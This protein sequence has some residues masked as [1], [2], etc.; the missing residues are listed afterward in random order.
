MALFSKSSDKKESKKEK[1]IKDL[2]IDLSWVIKK[3]RVT[4][5]A[6]MLTSDKAYTFD[7]HPDAN[8]IQIKQA[9][10]Q[11]YKVSP[12][13]VNIVNQKARKEMKR[14]RKVHKSGTKKAMV[15]L[16]EG[17]SIELV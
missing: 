6:A 11:T 14:G 15:Y 17:D 16:K 13:K 1:E 5:K 3:P 12:Q 8:K 10:E 9:I 7:V 2:A 4:E